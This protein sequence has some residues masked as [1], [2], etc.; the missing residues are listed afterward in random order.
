[1][2]RDVEIELKLQL[3]KPETW[4]EIMTSPLLMGLA[5]SSV[6][7]SDM[8]EARYFDTPDYSLQK[9]R[10][11]YRIRREG[12]R[13]VA[14]VKG[15]GSADGG[16][17]RRQEWNVVVSDDTPDA[18]VFIDMPIGL[19]LRQTVGDGPLVPLVATCFERHTLNVRTPDGSLIEVA[20]DRGEIIAGE[21]TAP[22][23]ELEL[24]LKEGQPAALLRLGAALAREYPLLVGLSSKYHRALQL[25]GLAPADAKPYTDSNQL[26]QEMLNHIYCML[27][28]QE[29]L[30]HTEGFDTRLSIP[31]L[32]ELWSELI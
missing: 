30:Q 24:E 12:G 29:G 17:H 32:L 4:N 14:T 23:L 7:Q 2:S 8:L 10:T 13:W 9:A 19:S 20:A 22:I 11:T 25:A 1:M 15:W 21:R 26:R 5:D 18:A 27:A 16:L 31:L 3:V 6:W 28:A